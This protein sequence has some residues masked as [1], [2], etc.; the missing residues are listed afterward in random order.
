MDSDSDPDEPVVVVQRFTVHTPLSHR[1]SRVS[2]YSVAGEQ[3]D[4]HTFVVSERTDYCDR[5]EQFRL[6]RAT[7]ADP[8]WSWVGAAVGWDVEQGRAVLGEGDVS[9]DDLPGRRAEWRERTLD[10]LAEAG[11][12]W[13]AAFPSLANTLYVQFARGNTYAAADRAEHDSPLP[14]GFEE[15]Y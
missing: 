12:Q 1:P 6:D 13:D 15:S 8:Y 5:V 10:Y 3:H 9:I 7:I 4:S 14:P 2:A 11:A